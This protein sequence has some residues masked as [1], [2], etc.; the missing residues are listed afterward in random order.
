MSVMAYSRP[1]GPTYYGRPVLK[2]P[3]WIWSVPL[4][5]WVG[6]VAGAAMTMGMAAQLVG[7]AVAAFDERCRWVGA[8]GGGIGTA[9]L[10]PTSATNAA[11]WLCFACSARPRR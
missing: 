6:G 9:L 7:G 1:N 3:V 8:V 4:Y 11:F 2:E 10:I 5:F